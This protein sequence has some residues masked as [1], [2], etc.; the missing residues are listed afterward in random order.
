MHAPSPQSAHAAEHATHSPHPRPAGPEPA[1][2]P[3]P[4]LALEGPLTSQ[5]LAVAPEARPRPSQRRGPLAG[6]CSHRSRDCLGE[7]SY[8]PGLLIPAPPLQSP[9]EVPQPLPSVAAASLRDGARL[10]TTLPGRQ[11]DLQG[12]ALSA[13]LRK[14][15]GSLAE[16]WNPAQPEDCAGAA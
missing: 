2:R 8:S 6:S 1:R 13:R 5:V 7:V 16:A 3:G 14:P 11:S 10:A 9:D 15:T 12:H 4:A